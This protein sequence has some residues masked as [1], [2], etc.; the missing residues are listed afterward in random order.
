MQRLVRCSIV[1][2]VALLAG[3]AA[4]AQSQHR[5][6][7][8]ASPAAGGQTPIVLLGVDGC[9]D[10]AHVQ[11]L[12]ELGKVSIF[13]RLNESQAVDSIKGAVIA[14]DN[15]YVVP[16]TAPVIDGAQSL[17]L[18][19]LSITGFDRVD[20]EAAQ[21]KGVRVAN[22]TDYSLEAVAEDT[23]ALMLSAVRRIPQS[24]S[25]VRHG[26]FMTP[27]L[28]EKLAGFELSGKT[29]GIVGLG[30]IGTRVAE[31]ARGLGMRTIAWDRNPKTVDGVVQLPL[32][33]LLAQSDVVSLHLALTKETAG[34]LSA[35]RLQLMKPGAVL[36]NT[37]RAELV[38][39]SAL[40]SVLHDGRLSGAALDVLT[41]ESPSNPLLALDNVIVSPHTAY[42]TRESR[43][44]CAD[45]AVQAV[46]TY[47][48][49][50][51]N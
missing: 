40:Y 47:L 29:L 22:M 3:S 5:T 13:G 25:A 15:P 41:G 20:L 45:A 46:R 32:D 26:Q 38:D 50:S 28:D 17:K 7:A 12:R 30:R 8:A 33:E 35:A 37:A 11:Q 10:E 9:I 44:R 14:I 36:I 43:I 42:H 48:S 49:A 24:D 23:V 19:V 21:A 6:A 34:I 18:V 27:P 31:I 16:M 2:F 39:E 4:T 51:R 1:V